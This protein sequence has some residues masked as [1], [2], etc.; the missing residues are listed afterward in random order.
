M[1]KLVLIAVFVAPA[2]IS[3]QNAQ[4]YV[5]SGPTPLGPGDPGWTG[6]TIQSGPAPADTGGLDQARVM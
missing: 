4:N 3:A 5:P 2:L 6:Q 1:K